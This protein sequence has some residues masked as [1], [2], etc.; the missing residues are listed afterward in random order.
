MALQVEIEAARIEEVPDAQ[1]D[2]E[3]V[4]G[5]RQEIL[6]AGLEG[7][8]LRLAGRVGRE[9]EDRLEDV[10]GNLQLLDDGDPIQV[11]HHQVEQDQVGLELAG[12]GEDLPRIRGALDLAV[13]S[14]RQHALEEPDVRGLIVD[15]EDSGLN[16]V[17]LSHRYLTALARSSSSTP[18]N[19]VTDSG[20][21]R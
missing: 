7:A 19:C 4:E 13:A 14:L 1:H 11:R 6:G 9:D 10:F 16:R 12:Q 18:R 21:V 5:L 15:D 3:A 20:F 17:R 8:L 2:L